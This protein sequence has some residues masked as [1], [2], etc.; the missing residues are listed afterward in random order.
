MKK[1]QIV[2]VKPHANLRTFLNKVSP[3]LFVSTLL[4]SSIAESNEFAN[5]AFSKN[6]F[7]FPAVSM[8][9]YDES[10]NQ[11]KYRMTHERVY[12]ADNKTGAV[13]L[14]GP[15][16]P[17][18]HI[19]G[20]GISFSATY[21]DPDGRGINSSVK[22]ELRFV[23]KDGI[24]IVSTLDS[25]NFANTTDKVQT[26]STSLKFNQLADKKGFYVVRMYINRTSKELTP[27]AFGYSFCSAIF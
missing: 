19:F 26:M 4:I 23:G 9:P 17:W 15:V 13:L 6:C 1:Q 27:K 5:G 22:A 16:T 3:Y 21:I 12:H 11:K 18:N 7:S 24:N 2:E 25:N 20:D 10:I 8:T 14:Y